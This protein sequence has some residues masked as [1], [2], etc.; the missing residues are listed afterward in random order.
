LI[1]LDGCFLKGDTKG[2]LLTA[3]G[4]DANNGM[5][6][7]AWAL[8]EAKNIASWSWFVSLLKEDLQL[9]DGNGLTITSDQNTVHPI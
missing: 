2:K 5:Y 3:V 9:C 4:K 6:P 7:I 8:V 1:G